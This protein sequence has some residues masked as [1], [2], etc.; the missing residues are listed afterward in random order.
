MLC[1]TILIIQQCE[2]PT[3]RQNQEGTKRKRKTKQSRTHITITHVNEV[4][5]F[6]NVRVL[7]ITL[8][9]C[10]WNVFA[11]VS[12]CFVWKLNYCFDSSSKDAEWLFAAVL[13]LLLFKMEVLLKFRPRPEQLLDTPGRLEG[14]FCTRPLFLRS[15]R[16]CH[17]EMRTW[18]NTVPSDENATLEGNLWKRKT[19]GAAALEK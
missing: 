10:I 5:V 8:M 15:T 12:I 6:Q 4:S 13:L 16:S 1:L 18:R 17:F 19:N 14:V 9:P 11:F 3:V 7:C 2:A